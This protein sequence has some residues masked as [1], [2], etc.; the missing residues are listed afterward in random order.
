MTVFYGICFFACRIRDKD[1]DLYGYGN[2]LVLPTGYGMGVLLNIFAGFIRK[3]CHNFARK[4][5]ATGYGIKPR[6]SHGIRV[7]CPGPPIKI[8]FSIE[9]RKK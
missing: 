2:R 3:L 5:L 9:N 8:F 4:N 7:T 6:I 1:L